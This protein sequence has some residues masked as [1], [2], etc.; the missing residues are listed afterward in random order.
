MNIGLTFDLRQPYLDQGFTEEETA[1][2]DHPDT[3]AALENAIWELGHEPQRIGNALELMRRLVQG[4]SWELVL[5]ICEGWYG[6]GR[7]SQVP[8]ILD[9]YQ[10]PY[11]FSDP[12]VLALCLDKGIT[13]SIIRAAGIPT[14]NDFVVPDL[15][16]AGRLLEIM[17][18][19]FP[20]FAKPIAEGTSKGIS[21]ASKVE[22]DQQ[23]VAVCCDLLRRFQQ[24]VLV[25]EFL[26]GREFTVGIV[27]TGS[28]ARCL[29]TMEILLANDAEPDVYSYLNKQQYERLVSYRHWTSSND[30]LVR[31][32]ESLALAAWRALGCRD[33]GRID[34]RC[35]SQGIPQFLEANP[36]AGL[37]PCHSDLPMIATAQGIRY[38]DLIGEIL[39]SASKRCHRPGPIRTPLPSSLGVVGTLVTPV[40]RSHL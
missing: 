18:P 12:C 20:L 35:D 27:G 17:R 39:E 13:K 30:E 26:P 37:H 38:Q 25:E 36:L 4:D 5:N 3:I 40:E 10:I 15:E 32:T 33:A 19:R 16:M 8:A 9:V 2:F 7:E 24:P 31:Q 34:V 11:T 1:E 22:N 14:P 29:G 21:A 28:Q 23:L 6:R